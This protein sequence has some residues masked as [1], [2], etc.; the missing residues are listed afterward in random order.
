MGREES[1][2]VHMIGKGARCKEMASDGSDFNKTHCCR[3]EI[4]APLSPPIIHSN[5]HAVTDSYLS[6]Q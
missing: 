1:F 3:R 2:H 4:A 6:A 5:Y